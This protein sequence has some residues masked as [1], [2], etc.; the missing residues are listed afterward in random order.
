MDY[1][2][3]TCVELGYVF[4][5]DPWNDKSVKVFDNNDHLHY[6]YC[7]NKEFEKKYNGFLKEQKNFFYALKEELKIEDPNKY[8]TLENLILKSKIIFLK[9]DFDENK[10]AKCIEILWE[11]CESKHEYNASL[12]TPVCKAK[13]LLNLISRFIMSFEREIGNRRNNFERKV[14]YHTKRENEYPELYDKLQNN[15]VHYPDNCIVLDAHD[16]SLNENIDLEFI[17][18][19][20]NLSINANNVI[21][22]LN[23]RKFHYLKE[24]A[25]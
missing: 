9:R 13:Y 6:S 7:V 15:N 14:I 19:D 20:N 2:L 24:F 18:S 17:T 25:N 8:I 23:I 16:L 10:K 12:K 5:T 21:S 22:F 4:C 1:F 3:D 11:F